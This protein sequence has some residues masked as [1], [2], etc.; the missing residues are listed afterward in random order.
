MHA[1]EESWRVLKP[2]GSLVDIRPY[3]GNMRLELL[4]EGQPSLA[5]LVDDSGLIPD[6]EAVEHTLAAGL[7]RG[8]FEKE[9]ERFFD[10]EYL[11]E[12]PEGLKDYVDENWCSRRLQKSL[13][14]RLKKMAGE[15]EAESRV[16]I[17][18]E[19]IIARY[20]KLVE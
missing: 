4:T 2:G 18:D 17:R 11:W 7:E 6:H 3:L 19:R 1:L 10:Y 14:K 16:R 12:S 15:V 9:D 8:L 13:F 5:G 20:K